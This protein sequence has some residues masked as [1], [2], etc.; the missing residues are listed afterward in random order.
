MTLRP[1]GLGRVPVR[2]ARLLDRAE[3]PGAR[4]VARLTKSVNMSGRCGNDERTRFRPSSGRP[5]PKLTMAAACVE[6]ASVRPRR[7][8]GPYLLVV[9]IPSAV[10]DDYVQLPDLW[11]KD[12]E[13]H[14]AVIDDLVLASP[15]QRRAGT[16]AERPVAPRGSD[17]GF[18]LVAL[19]DVSSTLADS[20]GVG[21][22]GGGG[23][24]P[25]VSD[26]RR[27]IDAL[28]EP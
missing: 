10:T 16:A 17:S 13:H 25:P 4:S 2:D 5:D 8:A 19:P 27:G 3:A 1:M 9:N 7:V 20:T 15:V 6:P 11:A 24:P 26:R 12:L 23:A 28:A 18:A 21:G 14:L 22:G